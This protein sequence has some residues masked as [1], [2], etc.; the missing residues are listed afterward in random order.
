MTRINNKLL[1]RIENLETLTQR[2]EQA[3]FEIRSS[4]GCVGFEPDSG[5][6]N[7]E[8]GCERCGEFNCICEP[9]EEELEGC[10]CED[11]CPSCRGHVDFSEEEP[12][13]H[14]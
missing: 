6:F 7:C 10:N 8:P 4:C 11:G 13:D 9:E 1:E 14:E 12:E 5:D 2:L 3:T